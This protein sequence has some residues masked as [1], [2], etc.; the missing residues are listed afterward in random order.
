MK[1]MS[2]PLCSFDWKLQDK[3]N[4]EALDPNNAGLARGMDECVN[5]QIRNPY[6]SLKSDWQIG[7]AREH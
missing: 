7:I 3:V 1:Y 4:R 5:V 6:A 2:V